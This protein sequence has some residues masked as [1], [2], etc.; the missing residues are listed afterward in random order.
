[1]D[2]SSPQA[3]ALALLRKLDTTPGSTADDLG[4]LAAMLSLAGVAYIMLVL[5]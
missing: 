2:R 4:C 3:S 1:M 5:A